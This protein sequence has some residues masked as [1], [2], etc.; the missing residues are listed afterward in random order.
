MTHWTD[1]REIHWRYLHAH[2]LVVAVVNPG[3][4]WGA[5]VADVR[6]DNG[7]AEC[8]DAIDRGAKLSRPVAEALW[9]ELA[10]KLSYRT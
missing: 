3:R 9:P 8:V 4:E 1:N 6:G 7:H 10:R 2:V 5:Y